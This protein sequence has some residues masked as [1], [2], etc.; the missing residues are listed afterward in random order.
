MAIVSLRRIALMVLALLG[1]V[2]WVSAL[3]MLAKTAQN[4]EEFGRLYNWILFINIAGVVVLLALIGV[5][6]VRLVRDYRRHVP[7]ARLNARMVAIFGVLVVAPIL[8]VYYFSVQF[9]NTGID[10]WFHADV[11]RGLENALE[12]SRATLE[13]QRRDYLNRTQTMAETI[14]SWTDAEI[15][16]GI[17][18]L[19]RENGALEVVVFGQNNRVV[20]YSSGRPS[21]E[22]PTG[23]AAEVE[24]Q[25]HQGRPYVSLIPVGTDSYHILT[26]VAAPGMA[27]V[28][29]GRVV[30]ALFPVAARI[31][32]LANT[33]QKARTRY[34]ELEILKA[35]LQTNFTLT[36]SLILLFAVLTAVWGAFFAA[37]RLVAPIQDL[38]AGT[39]AV[40]KGDF[41]TR[42]PMP[43]RDEIGFLVNSFNDMTMRLAKT[44]EIARQSEQ[45]VES[46]RASLEAILARLS[47]GVIALEPDLTVRT[48]N[49]A[50]STILGVDLEAGKGEFLPKLAAPH[51]MMAQFV[52]VCRNH[53]EAGETEW[54][55][56]LVLRAGGSR[57]V[58][59]C[60][61]TALPGEGETVG[62]HVV[63]FDDITELLQTQKEA[64][65]GEVARRLAH[66]IKNPLTPIQL[67]AERMRRRYLGEMSDTEA[68]VLDRATHTIVQQ[69]EA[70]K[71]MVN[72]F[73]EYARAPELEFSYVDVNRLVSE[74]S[75]LYRSQELGTKLG[76]VL[77]PDIHDL[78][79][80]PGR[81]RQM[82]HNLLRNAV[83]AL[84]GRENPRIEVTTRLIKENEISL[85]RI[86]VADNGPGFPADAVDQVFDP[87]VTSKPK[88]TGL[89]LAI[90]KK[91]V[92]EH[93]GRIEARNQKQGGAEVHMDFP[94]DET[95]RAAMLAGAARR[96]SRRERA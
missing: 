60:A 88:G 45:Q 93:G 9:L 27:Y 11:D 50:A 4:S 94:L 36:L 5:N 40:A 48:A 31:S 46:E 73:S 8:L 71:D 28:D 21:A 1:A 42:L 32:L 16:S 75:D 96:E 24:L 15:I 80:D 70:M 23:L 49:E 86:I 95:A 19:Q 84:E 17:G 68:Q 2:L 69:V 10:A 12:L 59:M 92:E 51:P 53:I 35:P 74:V 65:W 13:I 85:V 76:L 20:A 38:V 58:L 54:R 25:I 77:D 44:R 33:V 52:D 55:E 43:S 87:Y 61:C 39:R 18:R 64:A 78:E 57:R 89:G 83:E 29:E 90:V 41:D 14:T 7:G 22:F 37:R 56:Q 62:G 3:L 79:A 91:L 47:T 67:S 30:E 66:E 63:V 72:A 26:A 34:A 82:L 6:L 81:V